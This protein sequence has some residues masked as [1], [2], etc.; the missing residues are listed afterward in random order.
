MSEFPEI[1]SLSDVYDHFSVF[2]VCISGLLA[3]ATPLAGPT[4]FMPNECEI[5]VRTFRNKGII[6][7]PSA[8][9][10]AI[11]FLFWTLVLPLLG[12]PEH[13]AI[14][15]IGS[16]YVYILMLYSLVDDRYTLAMSLFLTTNITTIITF[17]PTNNNPT[18]YITTGFL[19]VLCIVFVSMC[20]KFH[21]SK[22]SLAQNVQ[23]YMW[24]AG[25]FG[26]TLRW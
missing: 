9:V 4:W 16:V 13:H 6:I 14:S 21:L 25:T 10:F 8:A 1:H 3:I 23:W 5:Y 24:Y 7:G 20:W 15:I 18:N 2:L 26:G 12:I 19:L 11:L 22:H 17:Y